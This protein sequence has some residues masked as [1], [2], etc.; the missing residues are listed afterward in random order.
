M[1]SS[2]SIVVGRGDLY[3]DRFDPATNLRQGELYLGEVKD[4]TI[5]QDAQVIRR[6]TSVGGQKVEVE[7]A[8]TSEIHKG[9]FETDNLSIEN[10]ALWFG[11]E[12]QVESVE[13]VGVISES[14][15]AKVGRYYQLGMTRIPIGLRYVENVVAK[16]GSTEINLNANFDVNK[17]TGRL[18]VRP[19]APNVSEGQTFTISFEWRQ[20][21]INMI[22]PSRREQFGSLRF[23][24]RNIRGNQKNY[25]YPMVKL[26]TAGDLNLN[27]ENNWQMLKF[28]F[29]ARKLNAFTDYVYADEFQQSLFTADELAIIALSGVDLG[30]FPYWENELDVFTNTTIPSRG[31]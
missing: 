10:L 23:V 22:S 27:D 20:Q 21:T 4:F 29:E 15:I 26:T 17:A 2:N 9:E 6:Y 12:S 13:A 14:F 24:S 18:Q 5:S 3:F 7:G 25:F 16:I 1:G 8:I 30:D 19:E 28:E 11:T 31:Y